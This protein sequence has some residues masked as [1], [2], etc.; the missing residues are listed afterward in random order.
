MSK[1]KFPGLCVSLA[2][3]FLSGCE[4]VG[5]IGGVSGGQAVLFDYQQGAFDNDGM[6][7]IVMPSGERFTGKFVQQSSSRSGNEWLLGGKS[8]DDGFVFKGSDTTM[9]D[10]QA[11]LIGDRKNTMKCQFQFSRPQSGIDGG[12]IGSCTVSDGEE[13]N[14]S[15]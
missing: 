11:L 13:V 15:F 12:G 9:S 10:T 1:L 8:R 14:V 5:T 6:L 3:L 4:S 7:T 2:L